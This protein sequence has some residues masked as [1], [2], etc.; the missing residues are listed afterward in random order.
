MK[1]LLLAAL[2]ALGVASPAW[3]MQ[4]QTVQ[5]PTSLYR[6][7]QTVF[8]DTGSAVTSGSVVNWDDDDTDFSTSGYP[9]VITTTTADDPYTAGVML[10]ESC[11]DQSLCEIIV[12]GVA[13]T[14]IADSTDDSA[15]DT[16]VGNSTV[17]GEAGD[18]ATGANTCALGTLIAFAEGLGSGGGTDNALARVFVDIDCD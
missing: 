14:R 5:G 10:T 1:R 3:A 2:L 7:T 18:Y 15:V 8:N 13:V 16:L 4:C 6:C 11:A 17:A 12:R 9:Y